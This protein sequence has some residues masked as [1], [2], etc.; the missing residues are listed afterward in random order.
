M[1]NTRLAK[2]VLIVLVCAYPFPDDPV[3]PGICQ[4]DFTDAHFPVQ[5]QLIKVH[6]FPLAIHREGLVY[7]GF[8]E[9]SIGNMSL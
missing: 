7:G 4:G 2:P 9:K 8:I 5:R 6:A 1:A 3:L